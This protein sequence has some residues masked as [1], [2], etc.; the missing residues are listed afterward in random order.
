MHC[1]WI[2]SELW[3]ISKFIN[4]PKY[5]HT[6]SLTD[7]QNCRPHPVIR[8]NPHRTRD[9]TCA[10]IGMFFLWCCLCAVWTLPFTSTGPICLR[11]ACVASCVLCGLGLNGLRQKWTPCFHA[12]S[13]STTSWRLSRLTKKT[14]KLLQ[15]KEEHTKAHFEVVN[16]TQVGQTKLIDGN[17]NQLFS[18]GGHG[19]VKVSIRLWELRLLKS[20]DSRTCIL[21]WC[22]P[23]SN[24]FK[25]EQF[26]QKSETFSVST[27]KING[28]G[29]LNRM[30]TNYELNKKREPWCWFWSCRAADWDNS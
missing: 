30:P 12:L 28:F 25:P 18:W 29:K 3:G 10:Q 9:V 17:R 27:K 7:S 4:F 20:C 16:A 15:N 19:F 6:F 1:I 8:P 24:Q 11:C 2:S 14:T 21:Q 26:E 23:N 13:V 22:T 5:A